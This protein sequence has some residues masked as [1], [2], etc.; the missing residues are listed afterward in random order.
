[1]KVAAAKKAGVAVDEAEIAKFHAKTREGF[2]AAS[3]A[4]FASARLWD[5][6]VIEPTETRETIALALALT[7]QAPPRPTR[8]GVFR[9]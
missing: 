2:E 6:G 4:T 8:Y 5:D 9:M 3:S 1:M 7:A